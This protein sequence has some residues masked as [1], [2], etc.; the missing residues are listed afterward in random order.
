MKQYLERAPGHFAQMSH[1][2]QVFFR[3]FNNVHSSRRMINRDILHYTLKFNSFVK[4]ALQIAITIL[5]Y[6]KPD[7]LPRSNRDSNQDIGAQE[8]FVLFVLKEKNFEPFIDSTL[9]A[10][11]CFK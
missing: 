5:R 3:T 1:H 2:F 11:D 7:G 8:A 4:R 9:E 6:S 10:C